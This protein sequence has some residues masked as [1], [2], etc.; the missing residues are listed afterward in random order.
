MKIYCA[1]VQGHTDAPF[2]HFLA[3]TY[4]TP[5]DFVTPF[6]RLERDGVRKRDLA[7][8]LSP[9][10]EGLNLQA[11][12]IFRDGQE[13]SSLVDIL[14]GEG[15]S[16]IDVNMGCPFPLQT[17]RGRGAATIARPECG[18]ALHKVVTAHPD[19]EFSVKLRLGF[20]DRREWRVLMPVLNDLPLHHVTLHPRVAREQYGGEVHTEDFAAFLAE[21][22]NPVVWSGDI[23]T[24]ADFTRVAELFP[25]LEGVMLGRGLLGRPSLAREI[26]D[27]REW[28]HAERMRMMLDFHNRLYAWYTANLQGGEHQVLSK[29]APFWEYAEEEMGRKAWKGVKKSANMARYHSAVALVDTK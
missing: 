14:S 29:I 18:E 27:G 1:P 24:P 19:I 25:Q 11:Q 3:E 7:D 5:L 4:G 9:L 17:A 26:T 15:I 23:R 12:V 22:R 8:L 10:N 21:S 13:L 20:A 2:R 28:T 16:R 6:I